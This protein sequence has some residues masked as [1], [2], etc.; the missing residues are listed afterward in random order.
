MISYSKS[1][2]FKAKDLDLLHAATHLVELVPDI[3]GLR[4]HEL[5]RAIGKVLGL[6]HQDGYYGF[7]DHTWL[8]TRPVGR[9]LGRHGFPHV[10][11]VYCVGSMPQVR[12]VDGEHTALPH[13]G[14]AYRPG[15]ERDDIDD[16]MVRRLYEKLGDWICKEGHT[17]QR[18][19]QTDCRICGTMSS[20]PGVRA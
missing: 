12:L 13:I 3:P 10:L 18:A 6:L 8:W 20:M 17:G 16:V 7:V 19:W 11:D 4:C 5:A 9:T 14:W 15:P 1:D 2:I